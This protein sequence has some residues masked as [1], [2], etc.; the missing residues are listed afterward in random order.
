MLKRIVMG[1]VVLALCG[2]MVAAEKANKKDSAKKEAAVSEA[3]ADKADEAKAEEPAAKEGADVPEVLD[4]KL[5][6][7]K[8]E[9]VDLAKYKGKV[10]LIV[11]TASE[12]GYTP[13]YEGLEKLHEKYADQGL[14][15][16]GFPANEFGSQEPGSNDEIAEFCKNNYNV[17]FDMFGKV[18]VAGPKQI[19]L[20][21][22]LTSGGGNPKFAGPVKWNFEKFVI[23]R[24]G[25]LVGRY[26]SAIPPEA[27]Q[28]I[29]KIE[30][31]LKKNG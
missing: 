11:N 24:D 15:V 13:Q 2:T 10:L 22:Y 4:F 23:S 26:P 18:V 7:L 8:G 14:A 28:L 20:Y 12:C 5:P 27:P 6:N 17:Q 30:T 3:Q 21:K 25:H 29:K 9:E 1:V 19:P 16:L 31:E